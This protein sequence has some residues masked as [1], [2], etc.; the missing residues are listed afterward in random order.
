MKMRIIFLL[1]FLYIPVLYAQQ[2]NNQNKPPIKTEK[3]IAELTASALTGAGL[4][5]ASMYIYASTHKSST[6]WDALAGTI[7]VGGLAYPVGNTLGAYYVG[8]SGNEKGSFWAAFGGSAAG[9]AVS[10]GIISLLQSGNVGFLYLILP[11]VGA[12]IGHNLSRGWA[13]SPGNALLNFKDGQFTA[14][15][16]ALQLLWNPQHKNHFN[17]QFHI[18]SIQF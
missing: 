7:L 6:G 13:S 12:V 15:V 8:N 9:V 3:I 10:V 16:P 14:G 18:L 17:K 2:S 5:L 1:L 11:P 4:A